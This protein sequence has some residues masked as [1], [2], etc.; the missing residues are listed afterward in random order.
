MDPIIGG[1]LVKLGGALIDRL[2]PDKTERDRAK[3]ALVE[4]EQK[5][6]LAHLNAEVQ[7]LLG[8]ISVNKIEAAGGWF[9]AG[10]R[11]FVGWVCGV[12]LAYEYVVRRFIEWAAVIVMDTP[13]YPPE[14]DMTQL[15]GVLL[16]ML[17]LAVQRGKEKLAGRQ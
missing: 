17:G 10:W 3:L 1:G 11:P 6:E 16:G 5:G 8:Q 4:L 7:L 2:F 9:R 15:I 12:A 14:L 13:V